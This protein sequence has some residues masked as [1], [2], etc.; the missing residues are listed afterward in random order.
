MIKILSGC[1]LVARPLTFLLL[2][3]VFITRGVLETVVPYV[4]SCLRL[5]ISQIF[6]VH[7][8]GTPLIQLLPSTISFKSTGK[9]L[10]KGRFAALIHIKILSDPNKH[11]KQGIHTYGLSLFIESRYFLF[12]RFLQLLIAFQK[13]QEPCLPIPLMSILFF[14]I[15]HAA[16][17]LF[18]CRGQDEGG[19]RLSSFELVP[20]GQ[21]DYARHAVSFQLAFRG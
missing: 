5:T 21:R 6:G 3:V 18:A 1:S 13:G 16:S 8:S 12:H 9:R 4:I 15:M 14:Q 17:F 19:H 2:V 11:A 10:T 7:I 20:G